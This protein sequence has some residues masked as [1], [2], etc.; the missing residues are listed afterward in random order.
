MKRFGTSSNSS[1]GKGKK[2]STR[3]HHS[4]RN[5]SVSSLPTITEEGKTKRMPSMSQRNN[6]SCSCKKSS[7]L[8][9][10]QRRGN[11]GCC[12]C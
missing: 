11:T 12:Y 5:L 6:K 10:G 3:S 7:S 1:H 9:T 8:S 2:H 4:G